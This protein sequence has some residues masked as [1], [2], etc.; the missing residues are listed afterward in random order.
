MKMQKNLPLGLILIS[1]GIL[2]F[3]LYMATIFR[4]LNLNICYNKGPAY[5]GACPDLRCSNSFYH[6]AATSPELADILGWL[7]FGIAF[8]VIMMIG[9]VIGGI[10]FGFVKPKTGDLPVTMKP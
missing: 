4:S 8:S 10:W 1:T 5:P 9:L 2:Q 7:N 3:Y 6:W